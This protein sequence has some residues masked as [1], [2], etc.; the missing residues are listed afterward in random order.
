VT[1]RCA[2]GKWRLLV[3]DRLE[4]RAP[5]GILYGTSRSVASSRK[6]AGE[7]GPHKAATVLEDAEFDELVVGSWLHVEQMSAGSWW[8]DIGGLIVNVTADRDGRPKLV[9]AAL[10]AREGVT[11][12]G[13]YAGESGR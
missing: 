10:E 3:H 6:L 12:G 11:Y 1:R 13:D 4:R 8:M 2:G 7:D 9:M 5:G